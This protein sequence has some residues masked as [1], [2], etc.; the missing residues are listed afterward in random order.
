MSDTIGL[1]DSLVHRAAKA[2]QVPLAPPDHKDNEVR[3]DHRAS[4]VTPVI[5]DSLDQPVSLEDREG[6]EQLVTLDLR[7][8]P[9]IK[10][11]LDHKVT[12]CRCSICK[13]YICELTE[14]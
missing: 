12:F 4:E 9:E 13:N 5:V 1:Q 6:L 11:S 3:M 14:Y 7:V 8:Q 2:S 10:A